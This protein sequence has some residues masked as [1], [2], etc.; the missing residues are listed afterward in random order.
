MSNL[1]VSGGTNP[2]G[3]PVDLSIV[4]GLISDQT[5]GTNAFDATGLTVAPGFIDIQINGAYGF[6]FTN[7]PT[8]IWAVGARLP[9]QGVT[10]FCPT[11]VTAQPGRIPAA[12]RAISTRP[13]GYVGA[14]P[15]GLHIEGPYISRTKRGT[16][17]P[18]FLIEAM[19]EHFDT[20]NVAIVTI[21]PELPGTVE[22][23]ERVSKSG[24]VVSL[25]H[26]AATAA[27]AEAAI[28]AGASMGTHL[29]NA[30]EPM[31]AR[32]P[33]LVGTLLTNDAI[34]PGIIV[35]GIHVS[36]E[37][38]QIAWSLASERLVLVTDAMSAAGMSEGSYDIA[39]VPV[40]VH[41]GSVRNRD[42]ALAGSILTID[43]A[44]AAL[45]TAVGTDL[46]SAIGAAT[47]H[48]AQALGLSQLGSLTPS[49][50][51]DLVL[52]NGV[53]VVATVVGG[54]VAFCNQ[55]DRLKGTSHVAEI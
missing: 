13:V 11:I 5:T 15:I 54:H 2:V 21:A 49:S 45:M 55:P 39:G 27:Q 31:T 20:T 53:D 46:E 33:G 40:H 36:K 32:D 24:V 35:D 43:K 19:P 47:L 3:A 34:Y 51:G 48:P 9:E 50:Q 12:Q 16:H 23:I 8:S 37:M 7:D 10:S 17:P 4:D 18:N 42:G 14:E 41:D 52:L 22:F 28:N 26:S 29:F 44:V 6:D 38:L 30:M 25:G 1:R